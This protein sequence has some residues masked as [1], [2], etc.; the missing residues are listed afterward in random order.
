MWLFS[1]LTV[2]PAYSLGCFVRSYGIDLFPLKSLIT[3]I[4]STLKKFAAVEEIS[5]PAVRGVKGF[6]KPG[7]TVCA[8]AES[9]CGLRNF[10]FWSPARPK[11]AQGDETVTLHPQR[12]Q[13]FSWRPS[14]VF[15]RFQC[16]FPRTRRTN[17][18]EQQM[19]SLY[20]P[21]Q[22]GKIHIRRKL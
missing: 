10:Y 17:G 3:V 11:A 4:K 5:G 22:R 20:T 14:R 8:Q 12:S 7:W 2:S 13:S 21:A 15:R 18:D 19:L 9:S 16:T 1:P 6:A